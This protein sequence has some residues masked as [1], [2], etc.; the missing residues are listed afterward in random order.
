MRFDVASRRGRVAAWL[1]HSITASGAV[2]GLLALT[3]IADD[4]WRAAF[5]WMFVACVVDAF[6]GMLARAARVEVVTPTFNGA[7]LDHTL[8]YFN[9]VVVP[10]FLMYRAGFFPEGISLA[11]ASLVCLASAYQFCHA[12]SKTK[13]HFF[14]GF[15]SYWN[16][17]ALYLFVG[18]LDPLL[19]LGI[20]VV[21]A[22]LAFVPLK[23]IYPSRMPRWRGVTLAITCVWGLTCLGMLVWFPQPPAWL[24][25]GSLGYVGYYVV[26]SLY[27]SNE[28]RSATVSEDSVSR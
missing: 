27:L 12:D 9:Y 22:V 7:L 11:T 5:W 13:D 1:V 15:P 4:H 28:R 8:D 21:L 18:H 17:L 24:W 6:D 10:A 16:I 19:N 26:V 25:L 14:R 20:V 3:A 2:W 23:W